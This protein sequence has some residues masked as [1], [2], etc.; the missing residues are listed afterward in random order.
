MPD[1]QIEMLSFASRK[2]FRTWL[3]KH[4]SKSKGIWLKIYKKS[5]AK[6]TMTYGEALDEVLCFGWIDGQKKPFDEESWL[7]RF[8]PRSPRSGWSKANTEHVERLTKKN[9]MTAA[10]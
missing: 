2:E 9:K 4:H 1:S 3:S 7:Q 6:A 10:G 8:T 5:S